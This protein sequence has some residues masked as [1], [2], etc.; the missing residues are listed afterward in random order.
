MSILRSIFLVLTLVFFANMEYASAVEYVTPKKVKDAPVS[1]AQLL[2][3]LSNYDSFVLD[4]FGE[5]NFYIYSLATGKKLDMMYTFYGRDGVLQFGG[6]G[7]VFPSSGQVN[8]RK[9]SEYRFLGMSNDGFTPVTNFRFPDDIPTDGDTF[10]RDYVNQPWTKRESLTNSFKPG[11]GD[12]NK[13]SSVRVRILDKRHD[14]GKLL[15]DP[16]D[17]DA[18]KLIDTWLKGLYDRYQ[19]D[20]AYYKRTSKFWSRSSSRTSNE[21]QKM[22]PSKLR[23]IAYIAMPP[24]MYTYGVANTYYKC[25]SVSASGYCYDVHWIDPISTHKS[26]VKPNLVAS[27]VKARATSPIYYEVTFSAKNVANTNLMANVYSQGKYRIGGGAWKSLA[28]P[29]AAVRHGSDWTKNKVNGA[30]MGGIYVP[31]GTPV[32]TRI[33]VEVEINPVRGGS[34]EVDEGS[35]N[36]GDNIK[37]MTLYTEEISMCMTGGAGTSQSYGSPYCSDYDKLPDG[38]YYCVSTSCSYSTYTLSNTAMIDYEKTKQTLLGMWSKNRSAHTDKDVPE[39]RDADLK[40]DQFS[41]KMGGDF[42]K[43]LKKMGVEPTRTIRA[44]RSVQMYGTIEVE[45]NLSSFNGVS[46]LES[47]KNRFMSNIINTLK[48]QGIQVDGNDAVKNN[49]G[50]TRTSVMLDTNRTSTKIDGTVY[51]FGNKPEGYMYKYVSP[52]TT[53]TYGS[54]YCRQIVVTSR[55]YKF[56]IPVKSKSDGGKQNTSQG[57]FVSAK[58]YNV[59]DQTAD[60]VTNINNKNGDYGLQFTLGMDRGAL[61][62]SFSGSQLC[63][64]SSET[65]RIDGNIFDDV[66]SEDQT[67]E[68]DEDRENWDFK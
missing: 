54:S 59:D 64:S 50:S 41:I 49:K 23:N 22:S 8:N 67:D 47:K 25:G 14:T 9:G 24:T 17:A 40:S 18:Q 13:P 26:P 30:L 37:R 45:L 39:A 33:D 15:K 29:M 44:G 38:T 19:R 56:V 36:Y 66:R 65:F 12:Y 31:P 60:F 10:G 6:T 34:R 5:G 63:K 16:T 7:S 21:F 52:T 4:R 2:R 42:A 46:D 57:D 53:N 3:S 35:G 48:T 61:D 55:T 32:G 27:S 58:S 20:H 68:I 43:Q 11:P 1:T 28:T 62:S 51:T